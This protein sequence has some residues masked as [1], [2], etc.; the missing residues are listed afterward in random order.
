MT[1]W[2]IWSILAP[3][4]AYEAWAVLCRRPTI[5]QLVWRYQSRARYPWLLPL[6]VGMAFALIWAHFF[7]GLW[8]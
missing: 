3:I 2:P 8:K 4:L 5:S 1:Y 6:L 7:A